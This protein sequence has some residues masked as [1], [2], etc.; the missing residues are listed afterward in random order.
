MTSNKTLDARAVELQELLD[1]EEDLMPEL[2]PYL[3][4]GPCGLMVNHPLVIETD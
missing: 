1:R 4:P 2:E 3:V